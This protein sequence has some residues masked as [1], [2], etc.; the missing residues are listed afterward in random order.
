MTKYR[1]FTL[2]EILVVILIISIL[3]GIT[4]LSSVNTGTRLLRNEA[5]RLEILIDYAQSRS[6]FSGEELG[7]SVVYKSAKNGRLIFSY[8]WMRWS[9]EQQNWLLIEEGA[10][11]P[12]QLPESVQVVINTEISDSASEINIPQLIF[13]SDATVTPFKIDFVYDRADV[14]ISLYSDGLNAVELL[15]D[16]NETTVTD[17]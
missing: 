12:N 3:L 1:G 8:Q 2:I 17:S 10:L 9:K 4:M 7:L 15:I 13:Y 6:L 14:A 5:N 11:K 16:D